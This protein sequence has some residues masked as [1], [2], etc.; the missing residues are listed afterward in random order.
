MARIDSRRLRRR[1]TAPAAAIPFDRR[2]IDRGD[3]R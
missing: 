3:C 2:P 1:L